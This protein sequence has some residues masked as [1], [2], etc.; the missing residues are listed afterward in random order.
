MPVE[1]ETENESPAVETRG[2]KPINKLP[3]DAYPAEWQRLLNLEEPPVQARAVH[4]WMQVGRDAVPPELPPLDEPW[5]LAS[6][7]ARRMNVRCPDWMKTIERQ[8]FHGADIRDDAMQ[9]PAAVDVSELGFTGALN[10]CRALEAASGERALL[11]KRRADAAATPEEME[12]WKRE[13]QTASSEWEDAADRLRTMEMAAPKI[14]AAS[15]K[16]WNADE[17]IASLETIHVA[18]K[19][20]IENLLK[21]VR[22]KMAGRP[23]TEQDA[24]WIAEVETMFAALRNNKFMAAQEVAA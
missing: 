1:T 12:F 13:A 3:V 9:K 17:V 20:S 14:L 4:R 6:W 15:G 7:Y 22:P 23:P 8:H 24:I 2:R 21:R 16:A 10:R 5:R 11:M 18:L 19:I